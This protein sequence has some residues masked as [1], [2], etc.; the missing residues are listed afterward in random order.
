MLV[1]GNN[2]TTIWHDTVDGLVKIIDQRLLPHELKI[3]D[4][5]TLDEVKFAIKEM[6]VRGA[7]LIG[8]TAAYGLYL[9]STKSV[10]RMSDFTSVGISDVG[11]S[12]EIVSTILFSELTAINTTRSNAIET[13]AIPIIFLLITCELSFNSLQKC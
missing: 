11:R 12:I 1:E 13:D 9:A 6:Q 8:V 4:L 7:P 3:V 2:L 10:S 5:N